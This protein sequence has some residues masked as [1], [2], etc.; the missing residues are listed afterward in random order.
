VLNLRRS[1]H[2]ILLL[3]VLL[4]PLAVSA[5][6]DANLLVL[7][8]GTSQFNALDYEAA[9][10]TLKGV[11]AASLS[12]AYQ[13][14][15]QDLQAKLAPAIKAQSEAMATYRGA[16][17][18]M[19]AG[20]F[21][22]AQTGFEKA[23]SSAHLPQS[24]RDTA[25]Q[26]LA[27]ARQRASEAQPGAVP[28]EPTPAP[29][30]PAPAAEAT[31]AQPAAEDDTAQTLMALAAEK[32]QRVAKLVAQGKQQLEAGDPEGAK[33]S[34]EQALKEAP[35][36]AEA[37]AG[38]DNAKKALDARRN[39]DIINRV[40]ERRKVARD[41]ADLDFD[42]AMQ[43]A[44]D[45]M[46][47]AASRTD[48]ENATNEALVAQGVLE[49]NKALYTLDE[50]QAK[51]NR[52]ADMLLLVENRREVWETQRAEKE[53]EDFI[54]ADTE[55]RKRVSLDR[56]RKIQS[57]TE[58]A[59]SLM[60]QQKYALANE[61]VA[62]ILAID[63][64]NTW[65]LERSELL[66]N[67]I[68]LME[69]KDLSRINTREEQKV[70]VDIRASEIPWYD[71][72]RY[73]SDWKELTLRRKPYA[74]DAGSDSEA[75]RAVRQKLKQKLPKL[76]FTNVP[77][78]LVVQFLREVS[79]VSIYVNWR[80]LQ[81]ASVDKTTEV[82]VHLSDVTFEKALRVILEDVSGPSVG[83]PT[84]V[85]YMID[86][87]VIR[88]TTN[89]ALSHRTYTRVYDIRDLIVSF[90]T[91]GMPTSTGLTNIGSS[92]G[93]SSRSSGG[94]L[95]GSST[96][97][98][99]GVGGGGFSGGLFGGSG[100][101]GGGGTGGGQGTASSDQLV[102]EIVD[103]VRETISRETWDQEAAIRPLR[104][105]LVVTQ[106]AENHQA[107]LDLIN[108][109]REARAL[110]IAVEARFISVSTGFLNS[111]GLDLDM[112]FNLDSGLGANGY[113]ADPSGS[114][115]QVPQQGT[116][117]WGGTQNGQWTPLGLIQDSMSFTSPGAL[118][119]GVSNSIAGGLTSSAMQFGGTFLDDIQV[120]FLIQ[121]TQAQQ[122]SRTLTAPRITLFNGQSARINVETQQSYV[123]DLDPEV[124][125][126][127]V[128]Y[129]Y[130]IDEIATGTRLFVQGTVSADRRY[131]TLTLVP[132]IQKI[133]SISW[134]PYDPSS[135]IASGG[136]GSISPEQGFIQLPEIQVQSLVTT[137]SV[138]DGGTLLLGGQK[139]SGEVEKEMGVPLLSKI[140]VLNR[141]FTNRAM[142]RD[143][144][145]LLILVKPKIIIQR[146]EEELRFQ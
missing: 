134:Y 5:A 81:V 122:T 47:L 132:Q 82:N 76:E 75:D 126:N 25:T 71:L 73:P 49:R 141:L 120:D 41:M 130:E 29:Q 56:D 113:V 44:I 137:V 105:Q 111:I 127:V 123:S 21:V 87:G 62:R 4:M 144:Q 84:E 97:G 45:L 89:E 110:Q 27:Q 67:F 19:K 38:L 33:A 143:E 109:L 61:E 69:E 98:S 16:E 3:V 145:T 13:R 92:G 26:Q 107:L 28:Q 133:I 74:V 15:Y 9:Q 11:D 115:A 86:G 88:I 1:P 58:R 79:G 23:Q 101:G 131:V 129:D 85:D 139:L 2:A 32:K 138:P 70:M 34:F 30:S 112:Y 10:T 20:K 80:A 91:V 50:F 96:G 31:E 14:M 8:K 68:V 52:V 46:K 102:N 103:L 53:R 106:T 135:I 42:K 93:G 121:A 39:E 22:E 18:A 83:Q 77:F 118:D 54:K 104:G 140:P 108:Q 7:K 116:S 94:G 48:F 37:Q 99:G 59:E 72:L 114:G 24:V 125:A 17:A 6:Q 146:E 57:L 51:R 43:R 100:G 90:P 95:S 136:A 64:Q 124:S 117:T 12:P 142:S 128:A 66:S 36:N 35:D 60:R 55:R 78:E 63:P 40:S 65:A 119:T